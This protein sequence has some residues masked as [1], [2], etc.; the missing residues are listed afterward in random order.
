L[1][2]IGSIFHGPVD[3]KLLEAAFTEIIQS[4]PVL[5]QIIGELSNAFH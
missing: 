4:S 5:D 3:P 2:G 1:G